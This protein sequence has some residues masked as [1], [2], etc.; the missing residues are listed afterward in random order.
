MI[1]TTSKYMNAV[2]SA[3]QTG[4]G[5]GEVNRAPSLSRAVFCCTSIFFSSSASGSLSNTGLKLVNY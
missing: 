1:R 3:M 2:D 4:G 5:L